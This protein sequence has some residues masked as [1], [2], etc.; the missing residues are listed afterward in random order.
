[1]K[2]AL[3]AMTACLSAAFIMD[4]SAEELRLKSDHPMIYSVVRGDTLWD[5]SGRF[6]DNPWMWPE[7][8][9][10]NQQVTNPD[11]I[12]PGDKINLVYIDGEPRL[13]LQRGQGG[14]TYKATVGNSNISRDRNKLSPKIHVV[15]QEEA[16][17]T[18]PL[19]KINNFLSRSRVVA[20]G[21][22]EKAPY[23]VAGSNQ[24]LVTGAGDYLYARGE[25]PEGLNV[26]GVYRQGEVYRDPVTEEVLGMAATDVATIKK[27]AHE[28]DIATFDVTRTTQEVRLG[29]R[30][31]E[32]VERS[33]SSSF[34][35]SAPAEEVSGFIIDV[36]GGV[37]QVGK[38][39]VVAINLGERN[40]IKIGDVLAILKKGDSTRDRI[41]NEIIKLPNE[42]SGLLMVF[43]VFEKMA[44]G[45]VLEAERPLSTGDI[46]ENP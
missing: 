37:N 25:F 15:P 17:T 21:E 46:I 36:E 8:W 39:D 22:L 33:I 26:Y 40:T 9:Q 7:I 18:I 41:T 14:R 34:F 24:R 29:D 42:K 20:V 31:L 44:F 6:L 13:K 23:V 28:R 4:T 2:K 43:R 1:M 45:L 32:T 5:I 30:L 12:Y 38:L 19:E 3:L 16:I 27:K 35:P 10:A 11:L